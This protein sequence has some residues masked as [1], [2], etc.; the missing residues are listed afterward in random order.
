MAVFLLSHC[1]QSRQTEQELTFKASLQNTGATGEAVK[2]L[3][4]SS[5]ENSTIRKK[6][7][8]TIKVE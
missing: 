7:G 6:S 3:K 1:T 2:A 5:P 4:S 8:E